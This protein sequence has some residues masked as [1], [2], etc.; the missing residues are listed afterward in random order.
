VQLEITSIEPRVVLDRR[1][2]EPVVLPA[3]VSEL[4]IGA[5]T[6]VPEQLDT[7]CRDDLVAIDGEPM[8]V[9]VV[10]PVAD[11]LDGA[12]VEATPCVATVELGAG[13]HRLTTTAGTGVQV[14]RT[15]L[16]DETARTTTEAGEPTVAI[17]SQDRLRREITVDD[18]PDGCWLVLG[19]GFHESWSAETAEGDLGPPQLVD[20]GFNG[21][22]IPPRD[23]PTEVTLRWTAQTPLT[24]A[25]VLTVVALLACIALAVLDRRQLPW[26]SV[27]AARFAVGE[28]PVPTRARWIVAGAWVIAAAVLVGW[29]WGL[30]AAVAAAV[31]VV[32]LGRPRWA[33]FLTIGIV[34][35]IGLVIVRV[36]QH[37]RPWPDAGWPARFEWLHRL[38]LFAAVSLAVTA[39]AGWRRGLC[40]RNRR[41]RRDR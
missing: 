24:V 15:V 3:A 7:G 2:G 32:A 6:V 4:S 27:P 26:P 34:A 21:W 20:G 16:A 28:P 19:E 33:G 30:V 8:P 29:G 1:Y 36:V 9:R 13:T 39:A 25:L 22:W 31:L 23:G 38:G 11:L 12:A 5:R 17:R 37:E 40:H 35:V 18:C 41:R 10:A 14:D